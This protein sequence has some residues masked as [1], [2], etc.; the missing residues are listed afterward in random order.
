MREQIAD[1][2]DA[3]IRKA[4]IDRTLNIYNMMGN[5]SADEAETAREKLTRYIETLVEA[6][7]N[8]A[9]R[10]TV[11]GLT[12]LR[13]LDHRHDPQQRGYTGM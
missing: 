2:T 1:H 12:F 9:Q 11:Y 7:E 8:N 10:L 13:E 3:D 4:T 6:G 5:H